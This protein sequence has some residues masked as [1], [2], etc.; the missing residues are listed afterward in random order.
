MFKGVLA[1]LLVKIVSVMNV[2]LGYDKQKVIVATPVNRMMLG[3]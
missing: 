2:I 1:T 3:A